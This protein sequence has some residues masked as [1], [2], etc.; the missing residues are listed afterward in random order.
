MK[1]T[2]GGAHW[3]SLRGSPGGDDYQN[4]WISPDDPRRIALVGDQ[5]GIIT[6]NGGATWSSWLNQPTA[7]LYHVGVTNDIPVSDLLGPAGKRL[8][9]ASRAAATR[10]TSPIAIGIRLE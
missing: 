10:A 2:D 1:S 3:T 8:G 5:G 7:Q 6:V 4:L 9:R